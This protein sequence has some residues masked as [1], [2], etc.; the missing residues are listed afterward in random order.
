MVG[1]ASNDD[2][3]CSQLLNLI[4]KEKEWIVE[5]EE[6]DDDEEKNLELRLGPPVKRDWRIKHDDGF[7]KNS[8]TYNTSSSGAKRVF[9]DIKE[10]GIERVNGNSQ[11]HSFQAK[12]VFS[13]IKEPETERVNDDSQNQSFQTPCPWR[14]QTTPSFLQ[15]QSI[16]KS[17]P[18][19]ENESSQPCSSQQ[20]A[21]SPSPAAVPCPSSSDQKR[22]GGAPVVGW[23]PIRSSRKN[24]M[25]TDP[26][27]KVEKITKN[28]LF[29]K[30][31]MEGVAIGR[32]VDL[33]AYDSY[34]K[35]SSVVD[36]LF[37]GLIAAQRDCSDHG[38]EK[39]ITGLL[40]GSGEYTLVYEDN[41]GERVL[42]GDVP[43]NMF[44]CSVRRLRVIK[45]SQI[46][47]LFLCPIGTSKK[48]K[49]TPSDA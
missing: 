36:E 12:R 7:F 20:K 16:P 30:I 35:L 4:P 28:G 17:I 23:P 19:M 47:K 6:D 26:C 8:N 41:E 11:N 21:F 49:T 40:D 25:K 37:R 27:D 5:Q 29:V 43:W 38:E 9:S 46:H 24:L 10:S 1:F 34:E 42:V 22:I 39:S 2:Y 15:L 14:Q 13:D 18:V 44:V 48:G 33:K 31:N 32:K 3:A 45:T